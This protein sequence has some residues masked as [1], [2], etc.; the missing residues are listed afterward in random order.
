MKP[1][2]RSSSQL[3]TDFSCK[4]ATVVLTAT[5]FNYNSVFPHRFWTNAEGNGQSFCSW[6]QMSTA[7]NIIAYLRLVYDCLPLVGAVLKASWSN[8]LMLAVDMYC[9]V[10]KR[11]SEVT[12]ECTEACSGLQSIN[13]FYSRFQVYEWCFLNFLKYLI[14]C[15]VMCF[16]SASVLQ[17]FE[18]CKTN[19][20]N[21]QHRM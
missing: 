5:I 20:Y 11:K 13:H 18:R 12:G 8:H 21:N 17:E 7:D 16:V 10:Q 3:N 9:W 6:W 14:A 15:T 19:N 4:Q 1:S 2:Y